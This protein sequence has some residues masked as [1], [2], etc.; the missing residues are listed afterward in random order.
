M[1][2]DCYQ[3]TLFNDIDTTERPKKKTNHY[4]TFK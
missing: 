3:K 1:K 2:K 4:N